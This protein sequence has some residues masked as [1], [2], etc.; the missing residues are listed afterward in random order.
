MKKIFIIAIAAIVLSVTV[1]K[2]YR[3][4]AVQQLIAKT[5][6]S[7]IDQ[8]GF[9]NVSI[10]LPGRNGIVIMA[11]LNCSSQQAQKAD[12]LASE[13]K[14][15]NIPAERIKGFTVNIDV[16]KYTKQEMQELEE[17]MA[18]V[19]RMPIPIVFVNGKVKSDPTVDDI[20]NEWKMQ[21]ALT[22]N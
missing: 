8:Y 1:H 10:N 18:Y 14:R 22:L 7:R 16:T 11:P 19:R 2:W 20:I 9:F 5:S 12:Y 3:H 21:R 17:R 6:T 4:K 13:L 15:R